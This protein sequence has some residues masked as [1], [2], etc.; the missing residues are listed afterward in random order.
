MSHNN[1]I[2][3]NKSHDNSVPEMPIQHAV[4]HNYCSVRIMYEII[5]TLKY[6]WHM[7][8]ITLLIFKI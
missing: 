1:I 4:L 2:P 8:Y 3:G 7:P 6:Y 5:H